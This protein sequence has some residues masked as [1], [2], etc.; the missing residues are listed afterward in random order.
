MKSTFKKIVSFTLAA[1]MAVGA[2]FTLASCGKKDS[3]TLKIGVSA[4]LTGVAAQYGIAVRNSA[5]LAI[6]EINAMEDNGLGMKFE[7]LAFNDEHKK[8]NVTTT[9]SSMYEKGMH[10]SIGTVTT[11]P[12]LEFKELSNDDNV[13]VLTPSATGDAIVE[14]YDNAYQMCFSDSNQGTA[15]A[16]FFNENY[17][18]K[19]IG[20]F[21]KSDDEYSTGIYEKF[22]A[23][24]C[25][26][27]TRPSPLKVAVVTPAV[28][29]LWSSAALNF[30][31][32]PVEYSSSDL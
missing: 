10:V 29:K 8:E 4:P 7:L 1:A 31:Y 16:K 28:L 24:T 18:G 22:S 15:S 5:Q 20:I 2:A 3:E 27:K 19:K 30:S 32:I 11:A 13:F 14:D 6:D 9:Y 12:G 26:S 21:Y 23:S 17:Q 25:V